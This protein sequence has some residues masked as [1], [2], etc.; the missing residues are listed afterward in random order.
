MKRGCTR[1]A[2]GLPGQGR[3]GVLIHLAGRMSF[4]DFTFHPTA[5]V[6]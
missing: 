6:R 3:A 1:F 2:G 4:R 5:I